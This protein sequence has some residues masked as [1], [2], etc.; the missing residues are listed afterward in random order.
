MIFFETAPRL[1]ESLADMA[2]VLGNRPAAVTR[3]L[4][5]IRGDPPWQPVRPCRIILTRVRQ[6]VEIVIVVGRPDAA[7]GD[8]WTEETI[9]AL[10][11][12][13]MDDEGMVA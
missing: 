8:N 9:D 1:A 12:K 10:I 4:T 5:K 7:S 3:E 2:D 11:I 13:M 6:R